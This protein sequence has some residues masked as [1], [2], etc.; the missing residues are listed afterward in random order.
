MST[1][2]GDRLPPPVTTAFDGEDLRAKVGLGYLLVTVDVDGTPR[3]CMLSCGEVLAMGD[4][5]LRLAVWPGTHTCVNLDRGTPCL[6]VFVAKGTVIHV[7]GRPVSLGA[8]EEHH[9]ECFDVG[10]SSVERDDHPGMPASDT[11]R[12][13]VTD[14]PVGSVV[15]EWRDRLAALRSQ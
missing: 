2:L 12:F 14:R 13:S 15:A 7:R 11:F 3:P 6:F 8:L 9:V 1:P 4:R 10:V 5:R